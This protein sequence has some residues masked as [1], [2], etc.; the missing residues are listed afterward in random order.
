MLPLV[1]PSTTRPTCTATL[2][3]TLWYWRMKSGNQDAFTSGTRRSAS[4]DACGG[5]GGV[6][7]GGTA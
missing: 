7:G 5:A 4:A 1:P 2:Q 3:S 6:G